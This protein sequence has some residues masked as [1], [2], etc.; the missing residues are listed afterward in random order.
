MPVRTRATLAELESFVRALSPNIASLDDAASGE[1]PLDRLLREV[2]R[3]V[4]E[5]EQQQGSSERTATLRQL[6]A[7]ALRALA[8]VQAGPVAQRYRVAS[9][10]RPGAFYLLDV[11]GRDVTCTCPGFEYRGACTHARTLK[12]S[13]ASD[14]NAPAGFEAV[15]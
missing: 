8:L 7:E 14:G 6:P 11:E 9:S 10:S 3:A 1:D 15:A 12:Q 5:R 13:L 4:A 2:T